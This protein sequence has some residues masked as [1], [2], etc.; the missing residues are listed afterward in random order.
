[1]ND[2]YAITEA[3]W[4]ADERPIGRADSRPKAARMI[5]EHISQRDGNSRI[6]AGFVTYSKTRNAYFL[7]E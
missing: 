3:D 2:V 5:R 1:M 4:S 6:T 7:R